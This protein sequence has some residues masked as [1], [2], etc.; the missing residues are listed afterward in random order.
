[1]EL[2]NK[3]IRRQKVEATKDRKNDGKKE[4]GR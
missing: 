4:T 3:Y 1:M 2:T